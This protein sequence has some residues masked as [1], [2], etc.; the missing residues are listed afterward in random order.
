MSAAHFTR[1]ALLSTDVTLGLGKKI[2]SRK[3]ERFFARHV[4]YDEF[5]CK[6]ISS[7]REFAACR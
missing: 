5:N 3:K 4:E 1:H 6:K 7:P 2:G